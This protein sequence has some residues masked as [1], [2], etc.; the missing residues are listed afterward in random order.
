MK[1]RDPKVQRLWDTTATDL[2]KGDRIV[3]QESAI[4]DAGAVVG[5]VKFSNVSGWWVEADLD[6]GVTRSYP[7]AQVRRAP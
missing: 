6:T 1:A 2:K 5:A 7:T 3:V 4:S